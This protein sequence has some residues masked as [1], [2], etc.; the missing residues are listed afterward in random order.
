VL[1]P[2]DLSYATSSAVEILVN[3]HFQ[4]GG[5]FNVYETGSVF[6]GSGLINFVPAA[7]SVSRT[8]VNYVLL[9]GWIH[10]HIGVPSYDKEIYLEIT[11]GETLTALLQILLV[12]IIHTHFFHRMFGVSTY[13]NNDD[14]ND[15]YN[16]NDNNNDDDNSNNKLRKHNCRRK[17]FHSST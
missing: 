4:Y 11:S 9:K 7:I 16:N 8:E 15:H 1:Y 2:F 14:N 3:G 12:K 17:F 13:N 6:S 10:Q 5:I